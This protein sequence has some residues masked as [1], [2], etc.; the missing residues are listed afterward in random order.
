MFKRTT[1]QKYNSLIL[2]AFVLFSTGMII[3]SCDKDEPYVKPKLSFAATTLTA[4]ESDAN[5][6]IQ[7]VL[8]K[9]APDDITID[10]TLSGTAVD[11]VTAG[12]TQP[13][14]YEVVSDYG[15]VQILKGETTGIIELDLYSDF[16]FED[17]ETLIIS[18]DQVDSDQIEI[19]RD[20]ATT[21][22]VEQEDG[23]AVV[24]EW[25]QPSPTGQADMDIL[26]RI[27]TTTSAFGDVITGSA[28][29]STTVPELVFLPL[30]A[31][32]PAYGLSYVYYD[33]TL[34][35]LNFTVTFADYVNGVV[36]A[37]AQRQK[38]EGQYTLDNINKWTDENTSK[39]VQTVEKVSGAFTTPTDIQE[40]TTGSR[41]AASGNASTSFKKGQGGASPEVIAAFFGHK[42]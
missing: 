31:E 33:G 37:A 2:S 24:L 7:V 10:F 35:P 27:G 25:P 12:T 3:S 11:D 6:E 16:L 15:T 20:D 26:L 5:L 36:E 32:I 22:T 41:S 28:E 30:A 9:E 18:I 1:M 8:D 17:D 14:D 19:T 21:V 40:P 29:G 4:K 39:V 13:S 42:K 34:N 23:T 38:Y